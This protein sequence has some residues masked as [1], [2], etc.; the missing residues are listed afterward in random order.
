GVPQGD[1]WGLRKVA[2][3][4]RF[5]VPDASGMV[6]LDSTGIAVGQDYSRGNDV[7][8][9]LRGQYGARSCREDPDDPDSSVM[10][11]AA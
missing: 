10:S 5:F 2:V 7:Y 9:T 3:N 6:L 1:F 4:H 8:R 11:V